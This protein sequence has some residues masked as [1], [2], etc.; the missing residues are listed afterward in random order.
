MSKDP[1]LGNRLDWLPGVYITHEHGEKVTG[2]T[3]T[4]RRGRPIVHV[5]SRCTLSTV[6]ENAGRLICSP[7]VYRL[8]AH[9]GE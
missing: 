2:H 6:V 9:G 8:T 4:I 5:F 1:S 7:K 3:I